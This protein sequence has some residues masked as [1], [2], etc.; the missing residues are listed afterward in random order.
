MHCYRAFGLT[1]ASE[2]ALPELVPASCDESQVR[3]QRGAVPGA[4]AATR[5]EQENPYYQATPNR[6]VLHW[7]EVGAF[8]V[9]KGRRVVVD[10]KEDVEE[11]LARLPLLGAVLA[12]LLMQRRRLV[13]HASAVEVRGRAIGF[14]GVKGAGKSTMS[15]A[16][17]GLGYPLIS[18]DL[19]AVRSEDEAVMVDPGFPRFKL[20]PEAAEAALRDDPDRLSKLHTRIRKR[21]RM[22]TDAFSTTPRPLAAVYVLALGADIATKPIDGRNALFGLLP[23]NYNSALVDAIGDASVRR[24]HFERCAELVERVPVRLLRR[25]ADLDRLQET[26][27]HI[28]SEV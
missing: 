15:A 2:F 16:L 22:A 10:L 13:L 12:A 6:V 20:S 18:D 4:F 7:P 9:E 3:V 11:G 27:E 19:L 21:A 1:I 17:H 25:P 23:H 8:A 26:A 14:V 5:A 28:A 24:W